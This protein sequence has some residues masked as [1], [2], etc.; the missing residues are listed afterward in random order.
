MDH[1]VTHRTSTH[2]FWRTYSNKHPLY[3]I[4]KKGEPMPTTG[5]YF[6]EHLLSLYGF[7]DMDISE[8]FDMKEK[9]WAKFK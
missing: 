7:K 8:V 2:V 9:P 6:P 1:Q 5:Y 3:Q 4:T